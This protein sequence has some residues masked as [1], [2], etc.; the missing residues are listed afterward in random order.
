MN[1]QSA[2]HQELFEEIPHELYNT[3]TERVEA[4]ETISRTKASGRNLQLRRL[5]KPCRWVPV[6][7]LADIDR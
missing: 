1:H 5:G 3:D 7:P 4:V 2:I 6:N